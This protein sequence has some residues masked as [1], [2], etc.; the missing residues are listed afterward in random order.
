[1]HTG[2]ACPAIA[3]HHQGWAGYLAQL[4]SAAALCS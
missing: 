1:V 3:P 2:L 4:A